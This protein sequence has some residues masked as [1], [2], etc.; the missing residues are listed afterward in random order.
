MAARVPTAWVE[1]RFHIPRVARARAAAAPRP[2]WCAV[3]TRA[4]ALVCARCPE[5]HRAYLP[6]PRPRLYQY[7]EPT[8]VVGIDRVV[9]DEP[10]V[11]PARIVAPDRLTLGDLDRYLRHCSDAPVETIDS[12]RRALAISAV[13]R[14]LRHLV[15][16]LRLDTS[17]PR[18][19]RHLGTFAVHALGQLGA[20]RVYAPSLCAT[21]LGLGL[22]SGGGEVVVRL[23]YDRRVLDG[24]TAC[25]ALDDLERVLSGEVL[26][27]LRYLRSTAA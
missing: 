12:F 11:L 8:A 6:F 7:G 13:P 19:A 20:D 5:L 3:F 15:W 21:T 14:P 4:Y 24:T 2:A 23:A 16:R 25:R 27:E 9:G 26:S 18:R 22:V 17:G 10:A 1:R